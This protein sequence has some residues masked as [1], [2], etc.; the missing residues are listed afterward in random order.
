[1]PAQPNKTNAVA[2]C[3]PARSHGVHPPP[4]H[5]RRRRVAATSHLRALPTALPL[6][7]SSLDLFLPRFLPLPSRSIPPWL[8]LDCRPGVVLWW[9]WAATAASPQ[10]EPFIT[11]WVNMRFIRV[12]RRPCKVI[13]SHSRSSGLI[14]G[15]PVVVPQLRSQN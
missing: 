6:G 3:S 11:A 4:R 2:P 10:M 13:F 1:M 15:T 7:L 8:L 9:R 12:A 5:H 14:C